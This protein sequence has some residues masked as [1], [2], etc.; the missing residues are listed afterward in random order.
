MKPTR[1]KGGRLIDRASA[2]RFWGAYPELADCVGCYLFGVRA[3]RGYVPIYVGQASTGFRNECF[4]ATKLEHYNRAM[5]Q[6]GRGTP[7]LFFVVKDE[8]PEGSLD[9]CLDHVEH[10]LIQ[11]AAE[12]N[13]EL[14]NVKRLEFRIQGV[15]RASMGPPSKAARELRRMLGI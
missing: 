2:D 1:G 12:K 7:V 9:S 6:R 5:N 3:S 11:M 10:F 15:F 14:S 4:E 8:G 13:A